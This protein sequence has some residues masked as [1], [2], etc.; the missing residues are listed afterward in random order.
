MATKAN[1]EIQK[2]ACDGMEDL[3]PVLASYQLYRHQM[4]TR[5]SKLTNAM[6]ISLLKDKLRGVNEL[7]ATFG[8]WSAGNSTVLDA[9]LQTIES[10]QAECLHEIE[11]R[12]ARKAVKAAAAAQAAGSVKG[13]ENKRGNPARSH[14]HIVANQS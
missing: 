4:G 7:K 8:L 9:L 10:L 5:E 13:K 14:A 1:S 6:D 11:R 12:N 3:G 2:L